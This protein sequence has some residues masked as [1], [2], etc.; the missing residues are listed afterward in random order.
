MKA[1]PII[2]AT[3]FSLVLAACSDTNKKNTGDSDSIS[4]S[5]EPQEIITT[6][7]L[8]FKELLGPVESSVTESYL[9]DNPTQVWTDSVGYDATGQ[10]IAIASF[11]SDDGVKSTLTDF[12]FTPLQEGETEQKG[13]SMIPNS[14]FVATIGRDAYG[15]IIFF[16]KADP[17]DP[18][19][20]ADEWFEEH[21]TW[22]E[23]GH[24]RQ[25]DLTAW[26]WGTSTI[27]E[28]NEKGLKA[29]AVKTASGIEYEETDNYTYNYLSFDEFGNWIEREIKITGKI[30]DEGRKSTSTS[31]RIERRRI[32][33]YQSGN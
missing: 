16:E 10:L 5:V 17:N 14:P 25:F 24:I 30:D 6:P 4:S 12:R 9:S 8:A 2:L 3:I 13:R 31:L 7:D 23:S 32:S 27:Y 21:Y 18:E 26:E 11:F 19:K 28:Y 1:T 15:Q 29:T 33:Y 20:G 22:N